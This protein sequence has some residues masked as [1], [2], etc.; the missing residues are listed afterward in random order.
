MDN[1]S[2][3]KFFLTKDMKKTLQIM[4][5]SFFMLFVTLFQVVAVESYSQSATVSVD[6]K[7][8]SLSN[9]FNTIER[10]SEFL[11]TYVNA[12]V[13]NVYVDVKIKNRNVA[14]VLSEVLKGTNLA[15]SINDRNINIYKVSSVNQSK[16][17]KI[18][19]KVSDSNGDVII[20]ANVVVKGTTNG[21]I[22]DIDGNFS[23]EVS[24]SDVLLI[25]YIG[26][27]SQEIRV[28]FLM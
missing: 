25:S 27:L 9:L 3:F 7:H 28:L 24:S 2:Y 16:S 12:D 17:R 8:I 18:T 22:T 23:I 11:F 19:G 4:R 14:S 10:Q 21:T 20:G 15:Y 26:F 1:F 13:E 5:I 6:A